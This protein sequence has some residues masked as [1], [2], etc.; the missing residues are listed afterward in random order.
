MTQLQLKDVVDSLVA[1]V[2]QL[3]SKNAKLEA[4]IQQDV[5]RFIFVHLVLPNLINP[6]FIPV[7]S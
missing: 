5:S 7:E 3:E 1:K 6:F 4:T 2:S